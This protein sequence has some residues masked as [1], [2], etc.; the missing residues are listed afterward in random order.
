MV[1]ETGTRTESLSWLDER[2]LALD[3][4]VEELFAEVEDI[5][6]VA[7]CRPPGP[8]PAPA[9]RPLRYRP[10]AQ[11]PVRGPGGRIPVAD[12]RGGRDPPRLTVSIRRNTQSGG[13]ARSSTSAVSGWRA[14][15][16]VSA[17]NPH[18]RAPATLAGT[19]SGGRCTACRQ[20]THVGP[21]TPLAHAP[22]SAVAQ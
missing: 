7:V 19:H 21:S 17:L 2:L 16:G 15:Q 10:L 5:L 18:F 4:D 12:G 11:K 14:R 20:A 9:P 8:R 13:D 1:A 6:R 3:P 22:G